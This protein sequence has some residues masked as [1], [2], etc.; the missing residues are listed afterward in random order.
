MM[1]ADPSFSAETFIWPEWKYPSPR[2]NLIR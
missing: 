1:V 2:D